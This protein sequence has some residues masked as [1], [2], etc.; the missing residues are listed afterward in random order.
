MSAAFNLEN[1]VLQVR[2]D[3]EGRRTLWAKEPQTGEWMPVH[4]DVLQ[5]TLFDV[6]EALAKLQNEVAR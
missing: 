4:P 6:A 1:I 3:G 5:P 2:K